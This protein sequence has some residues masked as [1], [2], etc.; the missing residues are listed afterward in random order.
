MKYRS[1]FFDLDGTLVDNSEGILNGFRH[2]LTA[3]G[4]PE[5]AGRVP[6]AVIG[7]P[8]RESFQTLYGMDAGQAEEAVRLYRAFFRPIGLYQCAVYPHV[9]AMLGRLKAAGIG[10]YL[11]TSKPRVFAGEILA[12]KGLTGYFNAVVG[13]ELDGRMDAKE[14]IVRHLLDGVPGPGLPALMVGDR[15]HDAEGARACGV[16]AAAALWGFGAPGEFTPFD[17]VKGLFADAG[18]LCRWILGEERG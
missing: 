14:E 1:V 11:A 2:A 12:H 15:W 18:E 10:L 8:L 9:E 4:L 7:P 17:N 3:L 16:D 6:M 13:S 5:E